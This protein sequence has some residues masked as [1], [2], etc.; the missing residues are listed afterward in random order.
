MY[1]FNE[2]SSAFSCQMNPLKFHATFNNLNFLFSNVK[3]ISV[4]VNEALVLLPRNDISVSAVNLKN[5]KTSTSGVA[6]AKPYKLHNHTRIQTG[7]KPYTCLT[8]GAVF[9]QY[10]TLCGHI[11]ILLCRLLQPLQPQ[12]FFHLK[13]PKIPS[14]KNE[15]ILYKRHVAICGE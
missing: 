8:C 15:L 11:K 1:I 6:Y 4:S 14:E 10:Y 9:Y 7:K 3:C 13:I 12:A 5:H 2:N